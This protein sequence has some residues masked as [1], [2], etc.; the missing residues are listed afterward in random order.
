LR[1]FQQIYLYGQKEK[2]EIVEP[3]KPKEP[4]IKI[5]N[6][7]DR[8]IAFM[9]DNNVKAQPQ[10]SV[11]KAYVIYEIIVEGNET[12]LMAVF[13]ER[14]IDVI[15]PMRSARHYFIDYAMEHDAIYVHLGESPQAIE[16]MG[17]YKVNSING[18]LYETGKARTASARFW[19]SSR[20]APHNA[21]TNIEKIL[22]ISKDKGYKTTSDT[23]SPFNYVEEDIRLDDSDI[24]VNAVNIPYSKN[25]IV[26]YEYNEETERYIRFSK[27]RK[28]TD[29]ETKEDMTAKNIIITFAYN[30]SIPNAE[31]RQDVVTVKD[32]KGYYITNGKAIEIICKKEAITSKTK[33]VDMQGNEIKINDGNTFVNICPDDAN[34]TFE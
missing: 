34:V 11:N 1:R 28:Q 24:V 6:G 7:K 5:F 9:I 21:Y 17:T 26:R 4:D 15:G 31:G 2:E 19:R 12:R 13:K 8:P 10:S 27:G 14:D 32:N 20:A 16:R 33:Y 23:K 25:H 3:A 18:Q 29:Q 22:E 30:Y